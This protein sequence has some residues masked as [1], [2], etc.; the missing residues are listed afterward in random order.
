MG[1]HV[2]FPHAAGTLLPHPVDNAGQLAARPGVNTYAHDWGALGVHDQIVIE[3]RPPSRNR[4][5]C[6]Y[7]AGD[8]GVC[9]G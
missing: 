7:L 8:A 4:C 3:A 5:T 9:I 6:K 2:E 1:N